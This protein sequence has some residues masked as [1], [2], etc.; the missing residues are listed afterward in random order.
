MWTKFCALR[1]TPRQL[2]PGTFLHPGDQTPN[3]TITGLPLLF[4]PF[5]P[6]TP[7]CSPVPTP[8][9]HAHVSTSV[10]PSVAH[11]AS[12]GVPVLTLKDILSVQCSR[13]CSWAPRDSLFLNI[14]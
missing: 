9:P 11:A 7:P 2:T 6:S 3:P 1:L 4:P 14:Y 10:F 13:P 5:L 12:I 8:G